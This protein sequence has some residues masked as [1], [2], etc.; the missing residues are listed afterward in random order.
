[1]EIGIIFLVREANHVEV[2][3]KHPRCV[4]GRIDGSEFVK[5]GLYVKARGGPYT[6]V[7]FRERFVEAETKDM[8]RVCSVEEKREALRVELFQ[9]VRIPPAVPSE[10]M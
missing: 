7:R 1:M 3:D 6:L 5:E 10:G 8:V 9:A 4:S 2:T